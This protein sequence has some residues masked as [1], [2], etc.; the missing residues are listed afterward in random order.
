MG[1]EEYI[2]LGKLKEKN[3]ERFINFF[4]IFIMTRPVMM[5]P[6]C[7]TLQVTEREKFEA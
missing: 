5:S 3:K 6:E 7:L 2:N 1:N 4:S